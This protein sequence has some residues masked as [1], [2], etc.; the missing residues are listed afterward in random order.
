LPR[1]SVEPDERGTYLDGKAPVVA[2]ASFLP[3][4]PALVLA[5]VSFPVHA[6]SLY[7]ISFV[8]GVIIPLARDVLMFVVLR[9]S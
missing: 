8:A 2:V 6:L 3:L 7:A 1:R 9:T 4:L 5:L